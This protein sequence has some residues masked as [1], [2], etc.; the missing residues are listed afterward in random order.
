[1]ILLMWFRMVMGLV[2]MS[3]VTG[4]SLLDGGVKAAGLSPQQREFLRQF[5]LR[6]G[7]DD[8]GQ[9]RVVWQPATEPD[10]KPGTQVTAKLPRW[11]RRALR[12]KG[13]GVLKAGYPAP[14]PAAAP[15]PPPRVYVISAPAPQPAQ[16]SK[17]PPPMP[18]YKP[19]PQPQPMASG[20]P[21]PPQAKPMMM[22]PMPAAQDPHGSPMSA[23]MPMSQGPTSYRVIYIQQPPEEPEKPSPSQSSYPSHMPAPAPVMMGYPPPPQQPSSKP[24]TPTAVQSSYSVS[25]TQAQQ[26]GSYRIIYIQPPPEQPAKKPA[27]P[28]PHPQPSYPPPAPSYPPPAPH[29]PP[30]MMS[31]PPQPAAEPEP[32]AA[33]PQTLFIL[34][35]SSS[36]SSPTKSAKPTIPACSPAPGNY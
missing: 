28:A 20:Y 14:A 16:Q 30:P 7:D 13:H 32:A 3:I 15:E 17:P 23:A 33:E 1:M 12:S 35:P 27:A 18:S 4:L 26:G 24:Q 8:A 6:N 25:Q 36:S 31:Y 9:L 10:A 22:Y 2:L 29:A 21:P 19:A 34:V 5:Q 11:L